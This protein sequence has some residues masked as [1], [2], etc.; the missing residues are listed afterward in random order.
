MQVGMAT[1]GLIGSGGFGAT[2][3]S[4]GAAM[5]SSPWS[6]AF[7]AA[8]F[9]LQAYGA[10]R[11]GAALQSQ[12]EHQA[13]V[14]RYNAQVAENN[15]ISAKYAAEYEADII[16]DRKKRIMASAQTGMAK[17]NVVINQDTPLAIQ[18][19][20]ATDALQDRLARLYAGETEAGAFRARAA[21][22][23]ASAAN[24]QQSGRHAIATSRLQQTA[25]ALKFGKSLLAP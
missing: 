20:I 14:A 19:R 2:M 23:L 13:N 9:G 11:Q 21:G 17:S 12:Y 25:A 24:L 16:D 8:S 15:A 7:N 22:Q 1:A 5:A 4:W 3:A 18:E 10:A 6:L